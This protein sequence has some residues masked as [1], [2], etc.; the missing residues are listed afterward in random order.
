MSSSLSGSGLREH[1]AGESDR[2]LSE[3]CSSS[4]TSARHDVNLMRDAV[5]VGS[6]SPPEI[7]TVCSPSSVLTNS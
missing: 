7:S 3:S 4:R 6:I 2:E 5:E 1:S